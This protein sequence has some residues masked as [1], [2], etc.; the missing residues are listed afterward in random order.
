MSTDNKAGGLQ[1]LQP[2]LEIL[3]VIDYV[4]HEMGHQFNANHTCNTITATGM[5]VQLWNQEVL[6]QLWHMQEFAV[7]MFKLTATL[8]FMPKV[9]RK[10]KHF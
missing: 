10:L 2:R 8:I 6:Q 5:P 4:T 7:P 3:L 1:A 9:S